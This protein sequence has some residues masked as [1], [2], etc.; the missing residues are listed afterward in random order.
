MVMARSV[1]GGAVISVLEIIAAVTER[2]QHGLGYRVLVDQVAVVTGQHREDRTTVEQ[3]D[4]RVSL[5]L[6]LTVA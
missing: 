4:Y 3:V 5:V 1:V 2:H 6:I